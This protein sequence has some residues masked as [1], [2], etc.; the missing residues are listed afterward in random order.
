[1]TLPWPALQQASDRRRL[2]CPKNGLHSGV[3]IH[4]GGIDQLC[5]GP[6]FQRGMGAGGILCIPRGDFPPKAVNIS[7]KTL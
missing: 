4:F 7:M 6:V 1:M 2:D 3:D 5:V